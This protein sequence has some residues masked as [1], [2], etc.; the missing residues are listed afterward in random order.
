MPVW[1]PGVLLLA[2][3]YLVVVLVLTALYGSR[4]VDF[5]WSRLHFQLVINIVSNGHRRTV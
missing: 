4:Y 3:S 1:R 2:F 5:K